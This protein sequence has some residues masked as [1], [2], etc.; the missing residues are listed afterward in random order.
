MLRAQLLELGRHLVGHHAELPQVDAVLLELGQLLGGVGA[1]AHHFTLDQHVE[2]V[3]VIQLLSGLYGQIVLADLEHF[4]HLQTDKFGRLKRADVDLA[5]A[6]EIVG[7]AAVE[8]LFCVRGEEVLGATAGAARQFWALGK[9]RIQLL[10]VMSGDVLHIAHVLVAALD[11]ERAH[12]GIHQV[13]QVGGLVVVLHRQQ[14]LVIGHHAALVVLQGVRQA[15]GLGAV[16]TVGA[17]SGLRVGDVALPGEGHAQGT[18]DKELDGRVDVAADRADFFQI[19]LAGQHQ[20]GE[21]GLSQKLGFFQ[22]ADVG[23]GAGVQLNRRDIQLEDAHVLHDQRINAGVVEL[24]NQLTRRLHLVVMQDGVDGDKHLGVEQVGKLHQPGN[25]R[26]AV[27]GVMPRAEARPTDIHGIGAMQDG[28]LGDGGITGRAEQFEVVLG[29]GHDDQ[30]QPW[31]R[32]DPA[33]QRTPGPA[34]ERRRF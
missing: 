27:A 34:M 5:V 21:T 16:A 29:Q 28:F 32:D 4:A 6:D 17:A 23:L 18:V 7:A 1:K 30:L 8:G 2:T 12:A 13:N 10:T 20:L 22:G 31:A 25:V 11:L 26:H 9:N 15:A 24:V 33:A 3:T 14:V 19:Q